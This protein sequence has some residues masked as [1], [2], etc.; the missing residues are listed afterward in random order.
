MQFFNNK[1]DSELPSP[2]VLA[3]LGDAVYELFVRKELIARGYGVVNDL[4][5]H[6]VKLVKASSQ[7]KL[8]HEIENELTSEEIKIVKKGRNTK[9]TVPKNAD[10]CDYRYSTGLE[11]LIGY[12]YWKKENQRLEYILQTLMNISSDSL[13]E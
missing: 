4:H 13:G 3:Y 1:I 2:L 5:M 11:A 9:S 12:L 8:L 6:T 10:M 7:A